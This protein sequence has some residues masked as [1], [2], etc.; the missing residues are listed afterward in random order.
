MNRFPMN[1]N[2]CNTNPSKSRTTFFFRFYEQRRV[3]I[4]NKLGNQVIFDRVSESNE[5]EKKR[6]I[7]RLLEV[8]PPKVI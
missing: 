1:S 4:D 5:F 6:V 3:Q 7:M 8:E 2:S